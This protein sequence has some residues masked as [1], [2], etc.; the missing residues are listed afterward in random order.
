VSL[1]DQAEEEISRLI[2]TGAFGAG[3]RLSI[4]QVAKRFGTSV[5]PIREAMARLHSKKV[6]TFEPN[7]GYSVAPPLGAE[8]ISRMMDAHLALEIGA[9]EVGFEHVTPA[10][11]TELRAINNGIRG[12]DFSAT[13][14]DYRAFV[15]LNEQFHMRLMRIA[16]NEF[17]MDAYEAIGYHKRITRALQERGVHDIA[18]LVE[19]HDAILAALE[20]GD[21]TACRDRLRRH[22]VDSYRRGRES[23]LYERV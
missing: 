11:I 15:K 3:E 23:G 7:K 8:E 1:V 12:R 16:E 18:R 19:E 22:I 6:L 14:E 9:L 10:D 13:V 17:L 2:D 20:A 5:V 4:A 21:K